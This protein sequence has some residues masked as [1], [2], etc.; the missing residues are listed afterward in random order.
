MTIASATN[1]CKF[2]NSCCSLLRI[3]P[4]RPD[5]RVGLVAPRSQ[6]WLVASRVSLI[7][8]QRR[9]RLVWQQ[10]WRKFTL[11]YI[12]QVTGVEATIQW[13]PFFSLRIIPNSEILYNVGAKNK[14][15]NGFKSK[16]G[17]V[18]EHN[19]CKFFTLPNPLSCLGCVMPLFLF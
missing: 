18:N 12:L 19:W 14:E 10:N 7:R 15:Q 13:C 2:T 17:L 4:L 9:A 16:G 5:V 8:P 11:F 1:P 3:Y 6:V